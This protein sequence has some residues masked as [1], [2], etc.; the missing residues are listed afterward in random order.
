[1]SADWLNINPKKVVH[2]TI[3]GEAI[4]I[5]LE[6]GTYYS[7]EGSGPEILAL[8]THGTTRDA[9]V[10]AL[11]GRYG[12]GDGNL[13]RAVNGLVDELEAEGLVEP[14]A[15]SAAD[16]ALLNGVPEPSP[17]GFRVPVLRKFTDLQELLLLDPIHEID[18]V[19]WPQPQGSE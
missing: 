10:T 16:S 15:A 8:I 11:E 13:A 4:L 17:A 5:Q 1:M 14:G 3:D 19:G 18:E 12:N 2:E 7:L 6:T 9:L